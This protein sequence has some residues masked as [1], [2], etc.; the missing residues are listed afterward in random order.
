MYTKAAVST[1]SATSLTYV[2]R[3][4]FQDGP[5]T[6]MVSDFRDKLGK[7][8]LR[9]STCRKGLKPRLFGPTNES[10][11]GLIIGGKTLKIS[12]LLSVSIDVPVIRVKPAKNYSANVLSEWAVIFFRIILLPGGRDKAEEVFQSSEIGEFHVL[13]ENPFS[14]GSFVRNGNLLMVPTEIPRQFS[15]F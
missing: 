4:R 12:F 15:Q 8:E 10:K 7:S 3:G 6:L 2:G 1:T 9:G 11:T 5:P 14:C 13:S